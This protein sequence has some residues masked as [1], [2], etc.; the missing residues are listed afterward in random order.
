MTDTVPTAPVA[1]TTRRRWLLP[2][3]AVVLVGVGIGVGVAVAARGND[4]PAAQPAN[5]VQVSSVN[6]A[7]STWM[8]SSAT[9]ATNDPSWCAAMTTWM[10]QRVV[11]GQMMGS[12]MWGDPD[13]MLAN[14]RVWATSATSGVPPTS[15]C[16]SMVTWMRQQ[17]NG[18][19]NGWMMNGS[20][21]GR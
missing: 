16:D 2:V 10:N 18:N 17:A 6:Q 11:N 15:W 14:C 20:M 7:C 5:A 19:W 12:M 9:A 4:S 3:V 21:M 13:R 1:S 8:T